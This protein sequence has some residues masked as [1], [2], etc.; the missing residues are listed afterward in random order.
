MIIII[1]CSYL[2]SMVQVLMKVAGASHVDV[3]SE[4]T[5]IFVL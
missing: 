1:K 4:R 3:P 2:M 5:S